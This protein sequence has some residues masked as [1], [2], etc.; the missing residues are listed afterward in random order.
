[1]SSSYSGYASSTVNDFKKAGWIKGTKT[2]LQFLRH[3]K[4]NVINLHRQLQ[5]G[6]MNIMDS[7]I[8]QK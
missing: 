3:R 1:M 7:N 4:V 5:N 8:L 2:G 6:S